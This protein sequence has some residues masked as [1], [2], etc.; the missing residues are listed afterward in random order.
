MILLL[1]L[2]PW[3]LTVGALLFIMV[4]NRQ[5]YDYI[6]EED[7]LEFDDETETVKVAVYQDRAYWV[8]QNVF[9]ESDVTREPD[10]ETARAI[11]TMSLNQKELKKLLSILDELEGTDTE[12]E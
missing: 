12:R 8:Y 2:I 6:D 5:Q 3:V 11:D 9:Y 4:H 10:F 1:A 7:Y